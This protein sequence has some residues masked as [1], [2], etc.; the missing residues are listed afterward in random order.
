MHMIRDAANAVTFAIGISSDRGK[1]RMERGTDG[2]IKDGSAVFGAKDNV[3]EQ[4]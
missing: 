3:D 4:E 1:V 2:G